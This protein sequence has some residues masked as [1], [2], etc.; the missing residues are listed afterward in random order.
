MSVDG[1]PD[2]V[3]MSELCCV[4]MFSRNSPPGNSPECDIKWAPHQHK[5]QNS[6]TLAED[7]YKLSILVAFARCAG[8]TDKELMPVVSA[9]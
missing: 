2:S 4:V 7:F 1:C 3:E 9:V 6:R 5:H 8:R